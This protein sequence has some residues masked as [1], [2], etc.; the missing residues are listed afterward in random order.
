MK[1]MAIFLLFLTIFVYGEEEAT[2]IFEIYKDAIV[3]VQQT[4]YFESSAVKNPELFTRLEKHRKRKILDTKFPLAVGSGFII[5]DKGH[6]VTNNHVI[7]KSDLSQLRDDALWGFMSSLTRTL[8]EDLFTSREFEKLMDDFEVLYKTSVFHYQVT[9]KNEDN[10]TPEIINF[11][12]T[13]DLA[14]LKIDA[15]EALTAIPIGDSDTLKVGN[16]VIAL[17]YPLQLMFDYFTQDL[18]STLSKGNISAIRKETNGIQHT[19]FVTFGNSGGPLLNMDGE[20]IG[21]NSSILDYGADIFFSIPS[22]KLITWLKKKGRE[23]V[24]ALNKETSAAYNRSSGSIIAG[25]KNVLETGKSLFI[26]LEESFKV[27]INDV[28]KGSTPLL[29]NDL[30]VG[31][32]FLRIESESQYHGIKLLVSPDRSDIVTYTPKMGKYVGNVFVESTPPGATILIDG[33]KMGETPAALSDITAE[34]H[35]L[36]LSKKGFLD[37]SEE[38][39]VKKKDTVRFSQTLKQTYEI[40]FQNPLPEETTIKVFNKDNEY[41]FSEK[42][43]IAVFAGEWTFVFTSEFFPEVTLSYEIT[44][45]K[46][47][48]FAP[49]Y[50]K[51]QIRFSNIMAESKVLIDD[52][53][54]TERLNENTY[55]TRIGDHEIRIKTA[56]YLDYCET[57][58]LEKD[59]EFV[60]RPLYEI[61]PS[62]AGKRNASIGFP[63]LI[64]GIAAMT[65]GVIIN[66]DFI[67]VPLSGNYN[68]YVALKWTGLSVACAGAAATIVGTL[69]LVISNRD[70]AKAKT[71]TEI[72]KDVSFSFDIKNNN[73]VL[74]FIYRFD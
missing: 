25:N 29:I 18:K 23:S 55:V 61:S 8:P 2:D 3:Y 66:L 49:E 50:Y 72:W 56:R 16:S 10:Y 42:D 53:D 63:T 17:G 22:N 11:D 20:V 40:T 60:V 21:I 13:L 4:L 41:T 30:E 39:V 46:K 48:S 65:A 64:G 45:N 59:V 69:F 6:I 33:K 35:T 73:P 68:T 34:K 15:D 44:D 52:I 1:F 27:Y 28:L 19:A 5:S 36:K 43:N 58:Q 37:Y 71:K 12:K 54:I 62:V 38:I 31:E 47:I 9:I 67:S 51:S 57:I 14:L 70:F 7:D 74:T 32:S 24:I 26:K